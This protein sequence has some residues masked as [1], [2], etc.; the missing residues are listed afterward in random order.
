MLT[1]NI[2]KPVSIIKKLK[3]VLKI[4]LISDAG[5]PGISDPGYLMAKAALDACLE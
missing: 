1:M 2:K 3:E 5:S 4:A